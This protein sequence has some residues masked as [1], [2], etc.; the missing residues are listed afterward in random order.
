MYEEKN[1]T[2]KDPFQTEVFQARELKGITKLNCG[3]NIGVFL[4]A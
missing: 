3:G 4:C 1:I 2:D